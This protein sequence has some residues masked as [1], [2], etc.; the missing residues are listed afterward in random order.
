MRT[1]MH[2]GRESTCLSRS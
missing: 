1:V 2:L